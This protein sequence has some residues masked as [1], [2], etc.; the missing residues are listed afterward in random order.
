MDNYVP[1]LVSLQTE[2]YRA[3]L[4][5]IAATELDWVRTPGLLQGTTFNTAPLCLGIKLRRLGAQAQE[6]SLSAEAAWL[7]VAARLMA[8]RGVRGAEQGEAAHRPAQGAA[9]IQR[10]ALQGAV[11]GDGGRGGDG[12]PHRRGADRPD[13]ARDPAGA[14]RRRAGAQAP[15]GWRGA[16]AAR[17]PV[18]ALLAARA[19]HRS[20]SPCLAAWHAFLALHIKCANGVESLGCAT[21]GRP[22]SSAPGA[23]P[24]PQAAEEG[25]AVGEG[26]GGAV[27]GRGGAG[28]RAR[29]RA[30]GPRAA[31]GAAG[32]RARVAAGGRPPRAGA[33]AGPVR[34]RAACQRAASLP[35]HSG[36][37]FQARC[38]SVAD[39]CS[40]TNA[41]RNG[42]LAVHWGWRRACACAP[43]APLDRRRPHVYCVRLYG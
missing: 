17:R 2:A 18:R 38:H 10:R 35:L 16:R 31:P 23:Q 29:A 6:L 13:G 41:R 3:V 7:A 36:G 1:S 28:Q 19:W 22:V 34:T 33:A 26:A 42:V 25:A 37:G 27:A 11:G 8:R 15:Q 20:A 5:A 43:H 9:D 24:G 4:R 14:W 30:P 12:H 21:R 32:R 39:P 40:V